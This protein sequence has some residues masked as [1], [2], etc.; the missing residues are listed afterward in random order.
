MFTRLFPLLSV[1]LS[2]LLPVPA[3]AVPKAVSTTNP[4][5]GI[6]D[7][8]SATFDGA[9]SPCTPSD[10]AWCSFFNGKAGSNRNVV[11]APSPTGVSNAVPLGITPVPA[12]GSYLELAVNGA[13]T[14]V[15]LAGGTVSFPSLTMSIQGGTPNS[16][17][18]NLGGAGLVFNSA[19]Q[20]AA[21]DANGRAEFLVNLA[22][23]TAVDFSTFSTIVGAPNGSCTGPLCA[24]VPILNLDMVRYRLVID[25]DPTFTAFT[26]DFIGETGSNSLLFA[27]FD[28]VPGA[29]AGGIPLRLD[30][31]NQR[32]SSGT[33]STLKW[34]ACETIN[35]TSPCLSTSTLTI[36]GIWSNANATPSD[37]VWMWDAS[38]G[39]LAM[40]G[41]FQSTSFVAS[42]ANG[43]PVISDKATNLVIDTNNDLTTAAAYQCV[44]GTFLSA[45]GAHGCLNT[46]LGDNF[47]NDSS[48]LYNVGGNAKCVQRTIGGDDASIGATRGLTSV[49]ATGPC[50]AQ[51]GAF[52]LWTIEKDDT[53]TGG[54]LILRNS[55]PITLAGTNYLTF[56]AA[57]DALDDGPVNALQGT[58]TSIDVLAN[59]VNFTDP[60]AVT[61]AT[62]GTKG[63]ATVVGTSPG[64]RSG[65]TITYTSNPGATG[66]DSFVYTVLNSDGLTSDTGTVTVS[67]QEPADAT[68]D[69]FVIPDQSAVPLSSTVTSVAVPLAGFNL[70]V[71]IAVSGDPTS[72]YSLNGGPFTASAG[73]VGPGSSVRVR[74]TSSG[75]PATAVD[76]TLTVG[77]VSDTFTSTTLQ[78]AFD[79]FASTPGNLPVS[80]NVLANDQNLAPAVF[81]GIWIAPQ[82]G[83]ATVSGAPG[84]PGAIRINYTPTAGFVGTD[85]FEYWVESGLV[86]DYGTV[87]VTVTDPDLDDDG[88]L[89]T[90]DNCS[91]VANPS[92][93][94]SDGDGYGNRCDGDFTG[95]SATNAQDGVVLRSRLGTA[96]TGPTYDAADLNCNG[97]I[98]AQDVALF[99]QLLGKPPG[100]GAQSP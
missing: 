13:R 3:M 35:T 49:A 11:F 90:V 51:D 65:I 98:N 25:Y 94:D 52:D 8:F 28:S 37:A 73:T 46:I 26:A 6:T 2:L 54:Q 56:T 95:N 66:T 63:V 33:L 45:V 75:A 47:A 36:G 69:P 59:D 96:S 79:D 15:T 71:T 10:P 87:H 34:K 18:A 97:F 91:Q 70:P 24:I 22:P 43:A 12:S 38:A 23:V 4:G 86:V 42:N 17:I 64:P 44:E 83:A 81:V 85:S 78:L 62:Q 41:T 93:C 19:P 20:F 14:Q 40:T 82:H 80:I 88:V 55:T 72:S 32:S 1:A 50:D 61:V 27:R 16:T 57:P 39:I 30:A 67:I 76:S 74:H 100:P 60:V 29:P 68:P 48:A 89:N 31:H 92:Q 99:R 84:S 9:L 21:L 77:G 58:S 5:N 7:L 53:A